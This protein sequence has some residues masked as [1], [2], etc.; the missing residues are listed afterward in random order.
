MRKKYRK[1][2]FRQAHLTEK[3]AQQN[4]KNF[5]RR[6]RKESFLEQNEDMCCA[7]VCLCQMKW[8]RVFCAPRRRSRRLRCHRRK[9]IKRRRDP[10]SRGS[11][12]M[13]DVPVGAK[14]LVQLFLYFFCLILK[15]KVAILSV[16]YCFKKAELTPTFPLSNFSSHPHLNCIS[17]THVSR[18]FKF[19]YAKS[20]LQIS[21]YFLIGN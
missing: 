8:S 11:Q 19:E 13:T 18:K 10:G 3:W 12:V 7:C 15:R 4:A 6:K 9:V 2:C 16:V 1:L 14:Q 20:N 5:R 17:I 21:C